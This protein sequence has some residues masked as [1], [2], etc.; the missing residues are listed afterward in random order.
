M[1]PAAWVGNCLLMGLMLLEVALAKQIRY[2]QEYIYDE[3]RTP[4]FTIETASTLDMLFLWPA[5]AQVSMNVFL[6]FLIALTVM[7]TT[8][9]HAGHRFRDVS[10]PPEP[11]A[12]V[13]SSSS[14]FHA[15]T[16]TRRLTRNIITFLII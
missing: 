16:P 1:H 8:F 4:N 13:S 2:Q 5:P 6:I 10:T 14:A 11:C 9:A 12:V 3:G 7:G 15:A